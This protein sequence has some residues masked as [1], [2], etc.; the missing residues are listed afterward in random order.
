MVDEAT[1]VVGLSDE[2]DP[3]DVKLSLNERD[4]EIFCWLSILKSFESF[5]SNHPLESKQ[6]FS[7]RNTEL[8]SFKYFIEFPTVAFKS[9]HLSNGIKIHTSSKIV[10]ERS[11][12]RKPFWLN[13]A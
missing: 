1:D 7:C 2:R 4:P 9:V 11:I 13:N 8:N 3:A 10:P 6:L 5:S 12:I